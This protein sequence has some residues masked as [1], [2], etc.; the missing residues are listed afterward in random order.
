MARFI[1]VMGIRL[2]QENGCLSIS[3]EDLTLFKNFIKYFLSVLKISKTLV[4][5]L[6]TSSEYSKTYWQGSVF[7]TDHWKRIIKTDPCPYLV[8]Y[9]LDI[10]NKAEFLDIFNTDKKCFI[11]NNIESSFLEINGSPSLIYSFPLVVIRTS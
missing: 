9:A 11:Q 3:P 7:T 10:L 2:F 1:A 4:F 6:R 5:F 8:K